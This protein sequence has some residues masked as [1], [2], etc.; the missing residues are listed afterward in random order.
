[1]ADRLLQSPRIDYKNCQEV[2]TGQ[3]SLSSEMEVTKLSAD[4]YFEVRF[5]CYKESA[6]YKEVAK[7]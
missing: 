4:P 7:P 6:C 1:M 3:S 5:D 2:E